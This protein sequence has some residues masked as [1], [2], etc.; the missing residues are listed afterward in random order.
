MSLGAGRRAPRD[1]RVKGWIRDFRVSLTK[2]FDLELSGEALVTSMRALAKL[3]LNAFTMARNQTLTE[4]FKGTI[5]SILTL[6][7]EREGK[8]VPDPMVK[9]QPLLRE[10]HA[11]IETQKKALNKQI[12]AENAQ[13]SAKV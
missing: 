13:I 11:K 2:S 6:L 4:K 12:A 10:Y 7:T 8:K 1:P 5:I 9:V 3:P